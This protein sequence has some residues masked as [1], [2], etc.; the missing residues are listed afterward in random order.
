MAENAR[1]K[2]HGGSLVVW[3]HG[4][5]VGCDRL[6]FDSASTPKTGSRKRVTRPIGDEAPPI[7][8]RTV[9]RVNA[10]L[11]GR[12]DLMAGRTALTLAEDMTG[13]TENVILNMKNKLT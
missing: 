7:D 8:A 10:A 4:E 11:A 13:M 2:E 12:P 3:R 1:A 5:F 6:S 9:E